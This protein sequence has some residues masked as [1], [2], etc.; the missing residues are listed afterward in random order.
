MPGLENVG[1]ST[2]HKPMGLHGLLQGYFYLT[3]IFFKI[4]CKPLL[5]KSGNSFADSLGST[6]KKKRKKMNRRFKMYDEVIMCTV[7]ENERF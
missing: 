7:Q 6:W 1:A 4:Q 5:G 2:S 3:F